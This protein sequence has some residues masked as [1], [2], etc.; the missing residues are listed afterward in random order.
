MLKISYISNIWKLLYILPYVTPENIIT[1]VSDSKS[2]IQALSSPQ[3]K[4]PLINKTRSICYKTGK[5][6]QLCWVPSHVGITGNEQADRLANRATKNS[7]QIGNNMMR[8]DIKSKIKCKMK[9][10][11]GQRWNMNTTNKLRQITDSISPLPRMSCD[12]RKWERTLNRLRIGHTRL[13]HGY[14]LAGN[15]TP[16]TCDDC[17]DEAPLTVKHLL[18]ECPAHRFARLRAF[19]S[20]SVDMKRILNDDDTSSNGPIAKYLISTG[21]LGSI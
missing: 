15:R 12:D 8:Y 2:S 9:Q 18:T 17:E 1:I 14:L 21:Y 5:K 13:T 6:Y 10:I 20:T 16:P 4:N 19:S 3:S 7:I 11:W